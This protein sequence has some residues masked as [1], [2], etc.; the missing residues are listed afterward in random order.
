MYQ[1]IIRFLSVES[2]DILFIQ[3][4]YGDEEEEEERT[5]SEDIKTNVPFHSF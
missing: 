1:N 3:A 4:H 5:L 2:F